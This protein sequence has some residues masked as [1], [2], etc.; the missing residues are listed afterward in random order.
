MVDNMSTNPQHKLL[1]VTGKNF[2]GGIVFSKWCGKWFVHEMPPY[3]R[4]V[5]GNCIAAEDVGKVLKR[6]EFKMEWVK[7]DE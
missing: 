3:L 6:K 1:H 7:E 2:C 4:R 5:L